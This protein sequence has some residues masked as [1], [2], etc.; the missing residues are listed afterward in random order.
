[1]LGS[2]SWTWGDRLDQMLA[3]NMA[4]ELMR[5]YFGEEPAFP[6]EFRAPA[7]QTPN[8]GLAI[9][10]F[11]DDDLTLSARVAAIA[12]DEFGQQTLAQYLRDV[13]NDPDETRERAIIAMFG[14]AALGEP[15]LLDIQAAAALDD[16]TP[17]ERLYVALA[18]AELGDQETAGLMYAALLEDFGERRGAGMRLNVG[19]DSDDILEATSL[20]AGLAAALGDDFAP[21]LF[22][23]T[24]QNYTRE[25]LVQLEQITYLVDAMPRMSEAPVQVAYTV[26]GDEHE[27][28]LERGE[29]VTLRL[30][31]EQLDALDLQVTEGTA[32]VSTTF[33]APFDAA[34]V[35]VDPAVSISRTYEGQ[36]GSTVAIREG[37][38]VRI[39]MTWN[40]TQDAVDGCYQV[41]DLLPS[42]LRPV[43]RLWEYGKDQPGVWYP[44]FVEGQRVSFCVGRG[45]TV[46]T[47]DYY[48]RVIGT[49]VYTAEPVVMQSQQA[50][51]SI[52]VTD[53]L[54]VSIQ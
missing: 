50:Q 37:D 4:Q 28:A 39:T 36:T 51:E 31:P 16:L 42:G 11:A 45:S 21:L 12:G 41:S 43:T 38:L 54:E 10:P 22:E 3:R 33:L 25:T 7:Y 17:R 47:I 30:S 8:G 49:G 40:L 29:S 9:L 13:F 2:L 32:G 19:A 52:G 48:A 15:L 34:S 27:E 18:A 1:V 23:Y 53:A 14:R 5:E 35:E 44:Y 6:A 46:K 24:T 26:D 20:A